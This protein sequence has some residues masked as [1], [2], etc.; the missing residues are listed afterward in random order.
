MY[1]A[2]D[3]YIYE[4]DSSHKIYING[5]KQQINDIVRKL[6]LGSGFKGYTPLFFTLAVKTTAGGHG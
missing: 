1:K 4:K 3:K 2:T 6:N 5:N